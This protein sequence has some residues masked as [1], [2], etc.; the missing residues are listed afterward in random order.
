M[1][2]K[3]MTK[4]RKTSEATDE[5]KAEYDLSAMKGGVRGKYAHAS[6]AGHT[7]RV[8]HKDGRVTVRHYRLEEGAVILA[9]DVR[10]YFPDSDSVNEALRCLIPLVSKRQRARGNTKP[11]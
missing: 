5:M 11:A 10:Q 6:Q 3:S 9:P 2:E 4:T 1:S 7:V 8:L